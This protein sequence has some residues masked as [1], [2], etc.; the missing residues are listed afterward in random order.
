M[1]N[2]THPF[3]RT[4]GPGPYKFI[5]VGK[6]QFSETFGARYIGP[7][8]ERGAGTCAHCST[9]IINIFVIETGEGRRF[10][11]G[12]DCI[13]KV[14]L[15]EKIMTTVKRAE[16]K[17][18]KANRDALGNKKNAELQ[19][20]IANNQD[21]F[22]AMPHPNKYHAEHGKTYLDWLNYSYTNKK[23]TNTRASSLLKELKNKLNIK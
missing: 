8:C 18:A 20:L 5:G 12:S 1:D 10:G 19:I 9:A 23:L 17:L 3:N 14:G 7:E 13:A 21:K 2:Q 22:K 4:L 16:L 15:P 11:V 6:I